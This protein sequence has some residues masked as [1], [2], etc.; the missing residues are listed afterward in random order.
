MQRQRG[1]QKGCNPTPPKKKKKPKK[2]SIFL[3]RYKYVDNENKIFFSVET[4]D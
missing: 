4:V 1:L 2:Q 3:Y